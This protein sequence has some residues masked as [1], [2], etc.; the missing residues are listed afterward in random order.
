MVSTQQFLV[1]SDEINDIDRDGEEYNLI[2]STEHVEARMDDLRSDGLAYLN[3]DVAVSGSEFRASG[4][5]VLQTALLRVLERVT[6]PFANKTL[7]KI[8]AEKGDTLKGL[9]GGSDYVAFQDMAGISSIDM[10]FLGNPYPYHS[11]YD[12]FDWM[13]KFGDPG[14]LYHKTMAQ[15][16]ALL[17][18]EL[19]DRELLTFDFEVYANAVREYVDNLE[20]YARE[21]GAQKKDL[22]LTVLHEAAEAFMKNAIEF[23]EWDKAWEDAIGGG[24]FESNVMAIKRIS[25]NTRKANFETHLLD[26]DG[27]VSTHLPINQSPNLTQCIGSYPDENNSSTSSLLLRLGVAMTKPSYPA[28]G[29]LSTQRT[30]PSPRSRPRRLRAFCLTQAVSSTTNTNKLYIFGNLRIGRLGQRC[31]GGKV[32]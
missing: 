30:S 20:A 16:W 21:Q 5:P 32:G 1:Q 24:G 3:V 29:T 13:D 26:I 27:G 18:L 4:S 8:W 19:A 11:C 31:S 2:G 12:N 7:R 6:D 14:F 10:S 17:I 25:H 22:D 15:V 9:G 23:H 28:Y